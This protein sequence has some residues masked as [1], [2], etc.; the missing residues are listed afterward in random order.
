MVRTASIS[1]YMYIYRYFCVYIYINICI[2]IYIYVY[3]YIYIFASLYVHTCTRAHTHTH[4]TATWS[5]PPDSAGAS[6]ARH[7]RC[8]EEGAGSRLRKPRRRHSRSKSGAPTNPILLVGMYG[9]F[10]AMVLVGVFRVDSNKLE[11]GCPMT[12]VLLSLV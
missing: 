9:S 1:A 6:L 7:R 8:G 5:K 4:Y 11:H 2:Y 10:I 12:V 3:I